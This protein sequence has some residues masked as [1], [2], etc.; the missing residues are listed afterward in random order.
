M[1]L[2]NGPTK[3]TVIYAFPS[4]VPN[5]NHTCFVA[6]WAVHGQNS[7]QQYHQNCFLF[8]ELVLLSRFEIPEN[9]LKTRSWM[10]FYTMEFLSIPITISPWLKKIMDVVY[11]IKL[12]NCKLQIL[13]VCETVRT[14]MTM[15]IGVSNRVQDWADGSDPG[16]GRTGWCLGQ[17]GSFGIA[18]FG[19]STVKR[20]IFGVFS[21]LEMV[22]VLPAVVW[23]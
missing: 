18:A 16:I 10:F 19:L 17:K 9:F 5:E 13:L 15:F 23:H 4:T 11:A 14:K 2:F 21:P 3:T 20:V 6:S 7:G 22:L 12:P 1:L 8:L